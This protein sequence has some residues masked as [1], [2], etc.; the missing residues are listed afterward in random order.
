MMRVSEFITESG[1]IIMNSTFDSESAMDLNRKSGRDFID[2]HHDGSKFYVN[3]NAITPRPTFTLTADK[4]SIAADGQEII[5][6]SGLP[7]GECQ[8][9]LWGSVNDQW[10]QEGDIQLTANIPGWYQIRVSQWPYQEQ[11]ITFNAS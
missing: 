3:S 4:T 8:V 10:T 7:D 11:E 1:R 2:G 9:M 5:T 6:I